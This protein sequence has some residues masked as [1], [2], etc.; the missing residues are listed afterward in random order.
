MSQPFYP[1]GKE[2]PVP[3]EIEPCGP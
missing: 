1:S 3:T 2:P